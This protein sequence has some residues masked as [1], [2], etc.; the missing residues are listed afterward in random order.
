MKIIYNDFESKSPFIIQN[1]RHVCLS[2]EEA[3]FNFDAGRNIKNRSDYSIP[4]WC[5]HQFLNTRDTWYTKKR[6]GLDFRWLSGLNMLIVFN[7][8]A[9]YID[10]IIRSVSV[11]I[12]NDAL[13]S[14]ILQESDSQVDDNPKTTNIASFWF[15][16]VKILHK[17]KTKINQEMAKIWYPPA[18][19]CSAWSSLI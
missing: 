13:R 4:F 10:T 14:S 12:M 18:P 1:R 8:T 16:S 9:N 19:W 17:G 7:S 2:H 3:N 11:T 6:L 15:L 5:R